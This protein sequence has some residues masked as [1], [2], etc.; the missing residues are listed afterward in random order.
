[1]KDITQE[2]IHKSRDQLTRSC[3]IKSIFKGT[4]NINIQEQ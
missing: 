2:T 1:M 3:S 4:S